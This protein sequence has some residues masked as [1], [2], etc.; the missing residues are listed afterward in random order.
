MKAIKKN[1]FLSLLIMFIGQNI[2]AQSAFKERYYVK[3]TIIYIE[4]Y[5]DKNEDKIKTKEKP[6]ILQS[7]TGKIN[8]K[9]LEKASSKC[10]LRSNVVFGEKENSNKLFINSWLISDNNNGYIDRDTIYYYE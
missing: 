8:P 2:F 1:L 4:K 7:N 3:D 6:L 9:I 5:Y 10:G